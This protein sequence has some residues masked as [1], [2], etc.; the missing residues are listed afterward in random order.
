LRILLRFG[1]VRT[2]VLS[3]ELDSECWWW[4]RFGQVHQRGF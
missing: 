1:V 3:D 4:C 2:K